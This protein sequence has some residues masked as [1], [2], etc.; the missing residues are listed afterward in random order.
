MDAFPSQFSLS[1]SLSLFPS[2]AR[3]RKN[4]KS[5]HSSLCRLEDRH[6]PRLALLSSS[7][8]S[9]FSMRVGVTVSRASATAS[10]SRPLS[11][12]RPAQAALQRLFQRPTATP[13]S[14]SA[15]VVVASRRSRRSNLVVRA[16][17]SFDTLSN[18][19][20]KAWDSIRIDGKLT[21]ENIKGPMREIRRA[22]LEAD[23]SFFERFLFFLLF[24]ISSAFLA[25]PNCAL[26]DPLRS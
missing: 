15:V 25:L 17:A 4:E 26:F 6:F 23:V 22:L 14:S 13:L 12:H 10:A 1:S 18:S 7:V 3:E 16:S 19:L 11:Q 2:F 9:S 21:A 5:H 24:W 8:S 20:S